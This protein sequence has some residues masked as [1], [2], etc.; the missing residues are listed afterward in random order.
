MK[1]QLSDLLEEANLDRSMLTQ[2]MRYDISRLFDDR[3]WIRA[4]EVFLRGIGKTSQT[5]TR[6]IRVFWDISEFYKITQILTHKQRIW[7]S[8]NLIDY[9]DQVG[10]D[11]RAQLYV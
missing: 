8:S 10:V 1:Q 5:P 2:Q 9:W 6:I 11:M 3:D 4:V 7:I